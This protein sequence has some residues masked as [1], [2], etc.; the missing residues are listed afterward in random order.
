MSS[1]RLRENAAASTTDA[2]R[3]RLMEEM[4]SRVVLCGVVMLVRGPGRGVL[5]DTVEESS[6]K[7]ELFV[8]PREPGLDAA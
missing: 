8:L 7:S 6:E 3:H 5:L 4:L 2:A 1:I